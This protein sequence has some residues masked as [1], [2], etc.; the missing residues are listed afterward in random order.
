MVSIVKRR[1]RNVVERR[2]RRRNFERRCEVNFIPLVTD[3]DDQ[4]ADGR[5]RQLLTCRDNVDGFS[6]SCPPLLPVNDTSHLLCDP[7]RENARRCETTHVALRGAGACRLFEICDR[8]IILSGGWNSWSQRQ[9][10]AD[11]AGRV[12]N[13]LRTHG[14]TAGNV[15]VFFANGAPDIIKCEHPHYTLVITPSI[16][17]CHDLD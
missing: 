13:V 5:R 17:L 16:Q 2:S 3:V 12:Y 1:C 8:A 11:N 10:H 6:A 4:S 14:F 7:V 15:N 9:W